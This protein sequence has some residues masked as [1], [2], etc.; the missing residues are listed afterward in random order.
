MLERIAGLRSFRHQPGDSAAAADFNRNAERRRQSLLTA[1]YEPND[2]YFY[3]VRWRTWQRVTDRP[4][5]AAASVLFF[6][7]ATQVQAV[8][9]AQRLE[10]DFLKPGGFVTTGFK[11]GQQWDAPNGWPPLEWM[12]IEGVRRY[13]GVALAAKARTAWLALNRRTYRSTHRMMEKYDVVDPNRPAGGGEYATQ[14][15]FGW[16]NG[17]ALALLA[18]E[19]ASGKPAT[20]PQTRGRAPQLQKN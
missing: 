15:G 12:T 14:D 9:V 6:G 3:D 19:R 20:A 8:S 13:G 11:T 17:V 18:Q 7:L 16:T 4:T 2:G 1:A 10:R 5:L